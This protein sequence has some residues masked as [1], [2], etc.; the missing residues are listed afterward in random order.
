MMDDA[1]VYLMPYT[2]DKLITIKGWDGMISPDGD[3]FKVRRR[4]DMNS[5]HDIFADNYAWKFL[6]V[7]LKAKYKDFQKIKQ[8]FSTIELSE[9]DILIN[10][11][12]FVNYEK[13]KT[14]VTYYSKHSNKHISNNYEVKIDVPQESFCGKNITNKQVLVLEQLLSI[15]NDNYKDIEQIENQSLFEFQYDNRK[16]LL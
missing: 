5:P 4:G 1:P 10:L 12:G 7:N 13:A 14:Q 16:G 3:F 11:Y 6:G 2:F 8:E 9:K 15:N